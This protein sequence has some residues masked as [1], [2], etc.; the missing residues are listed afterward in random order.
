MKPLLAV[1]FNSIIHPSFIS[2]RNVLAG[3]KNL[4]QPLMDITNSFIVHSASLL[5]AF[6][7]FELNWTPVLARAKNTMPMSCN[8]GARCAARMYRYQYKIFNIIDIGASLKIA[9]L[10][11]NIGRSTLPDTVYVTTLKYILHCVRIN[12]I[13]VKT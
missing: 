5:K 1:L 12:Y 4:L 8:H 7:L 3:V 13:F 2:T 10:S 11:R 9:I 6:R